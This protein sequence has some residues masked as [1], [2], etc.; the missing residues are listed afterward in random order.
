MPP[1]SDRPRIVLVGA[2]HAHL[3]AVPAIRAG[4]PQARIVLVDPAPAATYSGMLPGVL[5]GHYRL[6]DASVDLAGFARRHGIEVMQAAA[7]AVGDGALDLAGPAGNRRVGFDLASLDIGSHVRMPE[8]A[9]FEA[10]AVAV[11]PLGGFVARVGPL[12]EAQRGLPVAVIGAGVAGVEIALALVHRHAA[13]VTLVEAGPG[14]GRG[15]APRT[16]ALLERRLGA[17]GVALVAGAQVQAVSPEGVD[18]AGGTR[19]LARLVI[20]AAGARAAEWLAACLPVDDRGFVRVD[21]TLQ[22]QGHGTLFAAGDCA[23][24]LHAPRP[25]AGVYA[26]RQAPVLARNIV[27]LARGQPLAPY[28]PQDDFLKLVTL[29]ERAAVAEWHGLT[30]QGR[31][32]WRLK[33]RIDRGFMARL[34]R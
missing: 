9:G 18:L 29:G 8:V 24:M 28:A 26:V 23:A 30:L 31:W 20:G 10:H 12:L 11:K 33:D 3:L 15:L 32:L 22:V 21:P 1:G 34:A 25:K 6:R 19:I 7:V 17:Q 4:L 2:G 14:I 13:R 5:A 27:A 16:V